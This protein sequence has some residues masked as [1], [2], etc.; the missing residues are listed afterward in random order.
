MNHDNIMIGIAFKVIYFSSSCRRCSG[1]N[2]TEKGNP[3]A[4]DISN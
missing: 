2:E 3:P 1:I 4:A